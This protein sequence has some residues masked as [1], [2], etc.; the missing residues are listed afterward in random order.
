[1]ADG[2]VYFDPAWADEYVSDWSN[3]FGEH[4]AELTEDVNSVAHVLVPVSTTG[5]KYAP[6]GFLFSRIKSAYEFD[7][8][9]KILG[10][11]GIPKAGA[12]GSRYP[13]PFINAASG[14]RQIRNQ[15]SLGAK[16]D[17]HKH[18]FDYGSMFAGDDFL[19]FALNSV[20]GG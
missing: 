7:G 12:N 15:Y 16:H 11:V 17:N 14:R 5:S 6:P 13:F 4:M 9:G 10:L 19:V 2:R 8:D 1:V 20:F 18:G 3:E